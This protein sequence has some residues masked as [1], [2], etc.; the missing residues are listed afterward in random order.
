MGMDTASNDGRIYVYLGGPA[1]IPVTPATEVEGPGTFAFGG[2]AASAGDV[3]GDGYSDLVFGAFG[4]GHTASVTG[5]AFVYLGGASGLASTPATS[6]DGPDAAGF[7]GVVS[8]SH[9]DLDGDGYD[10]VVVAAYEALG[11]AGRV[12]VFPGSASGAPATPTV[13]LTGPSGGNFGSVLASRSGPPPPP[14]GPT[15]GP[16]RG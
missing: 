8:S 2:E 13:T 15:P 14:S 16:R 1:G 3:N 10:D 12:Y 11:A 6:I 9:G 5:N 7:F 4:D